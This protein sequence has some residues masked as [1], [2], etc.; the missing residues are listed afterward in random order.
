MCPSRDFRVLEAPEAARTCGKLPG[1]ASGAR[2]STDPCASL[3]CTRTKR[4]HEE[5]SDYTPGTGPGKLMTLFF[6]CWSKGVV[7]RFLGSNSGETSLVDACHLD[8]RDAGTDYE[9]FHLPLTKR[10]PGTDEHPCTA[11]Q[12]TTI[13]LMDKVRDVA[14]KLVSAGQALI[15]DFASP[16]VRSSCSARRALLFRAAT[17]L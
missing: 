1:P 12:S 14:A 16:S 3:R 10:C 17:C 4:E 2:R 7:G 11:T 13:L 15:L 8:A 6:F 9:Y 5:E